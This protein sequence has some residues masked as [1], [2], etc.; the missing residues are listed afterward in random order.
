M[1]EDRREGDVEVI[2]GGIV[3]NGEIDGSLGFVVA[4]FK[5][6][7]AAGD[8]PDGALRGGSVEAT[9]RTFGLCLIGVPAG[10]RVGEGEVGVNG[11]RGEGEE[12]E[13]VLHGLYLGYH[14]LNLIRGD[15]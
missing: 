15:D 10:G 13:R 4:G 7:G 14:G 9:A 3:A 12:S 5:F 2:H 1:H 6:D 8:W 11:R